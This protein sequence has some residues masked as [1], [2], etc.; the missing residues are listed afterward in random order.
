MK[1][2]K[3]DHYRADLPGTDRSRT[4]AALCVGAARNEEE[5]GIKEH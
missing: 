5:Q 3:M 1:S 2:K 4:G